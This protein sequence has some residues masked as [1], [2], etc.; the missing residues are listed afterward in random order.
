MYV[1]CIY[2]CRVGDLIEKQNEKKKKELEQKNV[3]LQSYRQPVQMRKQ[4]ADV[5]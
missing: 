5:G 3:Y 4:E 1:Y 2:V